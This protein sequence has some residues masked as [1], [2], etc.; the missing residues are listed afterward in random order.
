MFLLPVSFPSSSHPAKEFQYAAGGEIQ[1]VGKICELF[2]VN[3]DRV[4]I[5]LG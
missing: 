2:K 3:I 1:V 5:D 4:G